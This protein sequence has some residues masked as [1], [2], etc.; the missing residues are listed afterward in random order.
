MQIKKL[1]SKFRLWPIRNQQRKR[2]FYTHVVSLGDNCEPAYQIQRHFRIDESYLFDRWV[3]SLDGLASYLAAPSADIYQPS[4]LV[5]CL[6]DGELIGFSNPRHGLNFY[7]EFPKDMY[8][9]HKGVVIPGWEASVPNATERTFHL[10]EKFNALNNATN[11]LLFVRQRDWVS[12]QPIQGKAMEPQE[13]LNRVAAELENRFPFATFD[14]LCVNF[15]RH[16]YPTVRG[17]IFYADIPGLCDD[18]RGS[19]DHWSGTFE[20]IGARLADG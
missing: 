11:A 20:R 7:H 16:Y 3:T 10:I 13:A 1:A 15:S 4:H 2:R 5:P 14:V 9:H 12:G 6:E 17:E 8:L 18:W 19:N